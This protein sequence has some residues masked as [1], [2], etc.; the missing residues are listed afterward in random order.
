MMIVESGKRDQKK[1]EREVVLRAIAG[2]VECSCGTP[3][4]AAAG[5]AAFLLSAGQKR[6]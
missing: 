2:G 5:A 1:I 3:A 6:I 4:G